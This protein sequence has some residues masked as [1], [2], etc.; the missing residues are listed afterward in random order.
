MRFV[1][2][3]RSTGSGQPAAQHLLRAGWS[4]RS[5]PGGGAPAVGHMRRTP[6]CD[7]RNQDLIEGGR[8]GRH[9]HRRGLFGS[10]L[11]GTPAGVVGRCQRF[12]CLLAMG[13][14][15]GRMFLGSAGGGGRDPRGTAGA[16]GVGAGTDSGGAGGRQL[17]QTFVCSGRGGRQC[18]Q[19]GHQRHC[20]GTSAPGPPSLAVSCRLRTSHRCPATCRPGAVASACSLTV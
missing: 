5:V 11:D 1:T 12:G 19:H 6:G 16:G 4:G 13:R 2:G 18:Q 8:L 3:E 20:P 17:V 9:G 10:L 15:V 7:R 14:A